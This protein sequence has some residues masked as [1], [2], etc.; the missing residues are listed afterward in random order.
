MSALRPTS[1][2]RPGVRENHTLELIVW[3]LASLLS[4]AIVFVP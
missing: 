3:I 1:R 2:Q 4:R